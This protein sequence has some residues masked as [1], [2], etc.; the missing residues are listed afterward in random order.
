MFYKKQLSTPK[1]KSKIFCFDGFHGGMNG[2]PDGDISADF[3]EICFNAEGK[4]GALRQ[5]L[6][7]DRL[8]SGASLF[9]V[10]KITCAQIGGAEGARQAVIAH[11]GD[12]SIYA[13]YDDGQTKSVMTA[14]GAA[15]FLPFK[16]SQT[17]SLLIFDDN[18]VHIWDGTSVV[19]VEDSP[20]LWGA[21]LYYERVF[22]AD[23]QNGRLLRFS[24][25]LDPSEW[26][27][28]FD[29]G[30]FIE[31]DDNFGEITGVAPLDGSLYVFG[32]DK[33]ARLEATASQDSFSVVKVYAL[34]GDVVKNTAARCGDSVVF[35]TTDGIY[36]LA[37]DT[38][39]K[40]TEN[41]DRHFAVC[42]FENACCR[43]T[44]YFLACRLS[45]PDN[46]KILCETG[47][48][49]NNAVVRINLVDLSVG[50]YR[51]MDVSSMSKDVS[52]GRLLFAAE[53]TLGEVS[54]SGM[55]FQLPLPKVWESA[56]G[57]FGCPQGKKVLR[58]L[59]IYTLHDLT[60]EIVAD[61]VPHCVE[62]EGG[63]QTQSVKLGITG[64][65]FKIIFKTKSAK[66]LVIKPTLE[67]DYI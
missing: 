59:H 12:G 25:E 64:R 21:A 22:A 47:D 26:Q 24:K 43:D 20:R 45:F 30:G 41:L 61:G 53:G 63:R 8:A 44:E 46:R 60:T 29:K 10:D 49:C 4:Y 34:H 33:I 19:A 67:I 55:Y 35:L 27:Q 16:T 50:V 32:K 56:E 51:G 6:G 66:P 17:H 48:F 13:L 31:F 23:R 18:G 5:G 62:I 3:A 2:K 38:T 57:D 42:G 58:T 40:L 1:S 65:R 7:F 37:G 15:E 14:S 11:C 39:K 28:S 54:D 52:S 36:S 9:G